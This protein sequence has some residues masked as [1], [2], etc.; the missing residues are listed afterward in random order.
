MTEKSVVVDVDGVLCSADPAVSYYDRRPYPHAIRW[1]H[2]IREAGYKII[3][4]T[5]RGM[6]RFQGNLLAIED[7]HRGPLED[8]L[9]R[10]QVPYDTL[11]FGKAATTTFYVDDRAFRVQSENGDSDWALLA[12]SLGLS[13]GPSE[14][15]V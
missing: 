13:M 5:A 2:R 12:Q 7:F 4:Q 10:H 3:L 6:D 11:V 14:D 15:G 1:L 9:A 8:W